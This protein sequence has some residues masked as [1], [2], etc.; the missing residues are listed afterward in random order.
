[1]EGR[2]SVKGHAANYSMGLGN[3][4]EWHNKQVYFLLITLSPLDSP[5]HVARQHHYQHL[6]A[7][8]EDETR[9]HHGEVIYDHRVQLWSTTLRKEKLLGKGRK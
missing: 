1:M 8:Y 9:K 4:L 7:A 6:Q 2:T 5:A 3:A